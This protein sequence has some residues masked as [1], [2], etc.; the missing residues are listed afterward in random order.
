MLLLKTA[1][2]MG[3]HKIIQYFKIHS[4]NQSERAGSFLCFVVVFLIS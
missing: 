3:L 4:K 2:K 1:E